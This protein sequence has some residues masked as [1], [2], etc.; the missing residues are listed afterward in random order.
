MRLKNREVTPSL[1]GAAK[2]S[3]KFPVSMNFIA[4]FIDPFI[5]IRWI[6]VVDIFLQHQLAALNFLLLSLKFSFLTFRP[7]FF[8]GDKR[9]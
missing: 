3:S 2:Y 1:K 6:S 9:L 4:L 8:V 5:Q 7:L